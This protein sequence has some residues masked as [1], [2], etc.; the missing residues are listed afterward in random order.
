MP[1]EPLSKEEILKEIRDLVRAVTEQDLTEVGAESDL[2]EL[3][4]LES[5]TLVALV[6]GLQQRFHVR[7]PIGDF[8]MSNFSS[9]RRIVALVERL[10]RKK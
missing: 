10:L 5:M 1:P 4:I 6:G 2:F 7:M 3:G 8:E 9:L